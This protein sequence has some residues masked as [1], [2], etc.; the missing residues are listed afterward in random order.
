MAM[1]RLRLAGLRSERAGPFD[2]TLAPGG[3]LAVTGPSGAGKSL[4]LRMIADLDPPESVLAGA[5]VAFL[6]LRRLADSRGR[7]RLDQVSGP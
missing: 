6:A 4:M 5:T 1:P 7:L 2:F 3:C